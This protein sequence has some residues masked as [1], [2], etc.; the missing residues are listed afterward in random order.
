M[1]RNLL[2]KS[3]F[4]LALVL[5]LGVEC[6][7]DYPNCN[8]NCT[9]NDVAV[10]KAYVVSAPSCTSGVTVN[11]S[12]RIVFRNR[13]NTTRVAV[14]LLGYLYVNGQRARSFNECILDSMP[15]GVSDVL[16]ANVSFPC[17]ASMELR[18]IIVSWTAGQESCSD[19]PT[20]A[21]LLYTSPS[22]R[23]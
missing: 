11:A 15:P 8:W 22:P 21:C 2:A 6:V 12:L 19:Q 10:E 5:L 1:I 13:T 17:G 4:I 14:R 18:N 3:I 9:A 16:L 7:A 20:C 23:D